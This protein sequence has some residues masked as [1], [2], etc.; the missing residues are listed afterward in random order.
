GTTCKYV[1]YWLLSPPPPPPPFFYHDFCMIF[2]PKVILDVENLPPC[3]SRTQ[4]PECRQFVMTE[5]FTSN[6]LPVCICAAMRIYCICVAGC[7]LIPF[8]LDSF[9]STTHRCPKC[10]TSISTIKKL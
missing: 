10:R 1:E 2:S 8:C 4:C 6:Y 3:P 7:C 9:K 5:T